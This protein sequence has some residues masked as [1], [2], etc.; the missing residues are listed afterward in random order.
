MLS[1]LDD[2]TKLSESDDTK[3]WNAYNKEFESA[4]HYRR[5]K[6]ELTFIISHYA[7]DVSSNYCF[8]CQ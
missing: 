6:D 3:L 7:G 2:Q 8:E 4:E 5:H 1:I